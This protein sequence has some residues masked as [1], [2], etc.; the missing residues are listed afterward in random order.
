M[1]I[2]S[3]CVLKL[4]IKT[5]PYPTE[6]DAINMTSKSLNKFQFQ[7]HKYGIT[8]NKTWNIPV[9]HQEQVITSFITKNIKIAL[10]HLSGWMCIPRNKNTNT[11]VVCCSIWYNEKLYETFDWVKKNANYKRIKM[12]SENIILKKWK[13]IHHEKEWNKI[14][15]FNNKGQLSYAYSLSKDKNIDVHKPIVSYYKHPMRR[16]FN[17][18]GRVLIFLLKEAKNIKHMNL[19]NIKDL[20][21]TIEGKIQAWK[22]DT[23]GDDEIWMAVTDDI[24]NMYTMLPHKSIIKMVRW[25]VDLHATNKRRQTE[26]I[27]V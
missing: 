20:Q 12:T 18:A 9:N 2:P 24:K 4:N 23:L 5:I 13:Q 19:W 27:S 16:L 3:L 14:I 8:S 17:V 10:N 26:I 11:I 1:Y 7:L 25:L 15:N 22:D 6:F 21:T